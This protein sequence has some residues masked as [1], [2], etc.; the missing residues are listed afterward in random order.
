MNER[1]ATFMSMMVFASIEP[2]PE[3]FK[4]HNFVEVKEELVRIHEKVR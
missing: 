3:G 2:R 1:H 4:E